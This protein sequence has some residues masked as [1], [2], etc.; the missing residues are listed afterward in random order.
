[1]RSV[2]EAMAPTVAFAKPRSSAPGF[3]AAISLI[4]E[5]GAPM[6]FRLDTPRT[7]NLEFRRV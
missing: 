6:G 2:L 5:N 7:R 3:Q 4:V 1:V